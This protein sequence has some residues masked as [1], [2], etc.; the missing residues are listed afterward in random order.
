[1]PMRGFP[2]QFPLERLRMF[3]GANGGSPMAIRA[4]CAGLIRRASG[5]P[6]FALMSWTVVSQLIS[7]ASMLV[8]L[9]IFQPEQFGIFSV[10]LNAAVTLGIILSARYEFAIGLPE[11]D[12]EA[13]AIFSLCAVLATL[14]IPLLWVLLGIFPLTLIT[15]KFAPLEPWTAAL[16]VCAAATAWMNAAIYLRLRQSGF[17]SV[18]RSKVIAAVCLAGGQAVAG[19][20]VSRSIGSLI[21][22]LVL[23]QAAT[24]GYLT[25]TAQSR[26]V[27]DLKVSHMAAAARRFVRFPLYVAPGSLLDGLTALIPVAGIAAIYS[28]AQAGIYALADRTMRVP[29]TLVGS[30]MMAVFYQRAASVRHDTYA[31]RRLLLRA[32]RSMALFAIPP[33]LVVLLFG[34]Q[35]FG[36]VFGK[37]WMQSGEVAR[38][39]TVSIA[40]FFVSYPTS[41]IMVI[42]ERTRAYLTWQVFQITAIGLALIVAAKFAPGDML[43]G[44]AAIVVAQIATNL[45]SMLLQWQAIS[46]DAPANFSAEFQDVC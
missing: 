28:P 24:A 18:G 32:W 7:I 43:V 21:V 4:L 16:A 38:I 45:T 42:R 39:M 27:F 34:P 22:P 44:I 13:T 46:Q 31:S 6:V 37:T 36:L 40:I 9:R 41:N 19:L 8:L 23:S 12:A 17:D 3:L 11:S 20:M 26:P 14:A 25:Y 15:T 30:S 29:V 5:G 2:I 35:L 1:M 33:C 10:F